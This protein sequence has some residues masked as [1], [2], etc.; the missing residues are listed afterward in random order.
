MGNRL[1][2]IVTKTGDKGQTGLGDGSRVPKHHALVNSYGGVDELNSAIGLA[3]CYVEDKA[4]KTQL[5]K[6]QHQL[7]DLGG[8][9]CVPGMNLLKTNS[10]NFIEESLTQLNESLKPLEE[11]I[12]PGG[13][14][15]SAHLHLA[16]AICRRVERDLCLAQQTVEI[17]AEAIQYLNRLSDYLFIAARYNN[18][19]L[20][21]VL[22]QKD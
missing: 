3:I 16:R 22:W 5:L 8:E 6:V 15:A 21:D 10:L 4:V 11:F 1:S 14:K 17:R 20:G 9:L 2:K 13:S 7:F 18:K 12:L 19:Q